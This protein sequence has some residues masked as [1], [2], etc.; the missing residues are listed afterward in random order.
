MRGHGGVVILRPHTER[1]KNTKMK[2]VAKLIVKVDSLCLPLSLK[3]L[4]YTGI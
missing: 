3:R 2:K 1:K 4:K